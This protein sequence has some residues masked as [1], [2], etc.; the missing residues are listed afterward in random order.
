MLPFWAEI[1]LSLVA[2]GATASAVSLRARERRAL[3][4]LALRERRGHFLGE[5]PDLRQILKH[6]FSAAAEVLPVTRFDLYRVGSDF[7]VEEVWSVSSPGPGS[8]PEPVLEANSSHLGERIDPARLR[9]I[10]ATE[11]DRSFAPRDLL[12]GGPPSRRLRLPLYSGDRLIAHLDMTSSETVADATREEIRSLLGPLTASLH[13]FRNWT[14]AVTDELSGLASRRY[15][16]TRLSEEW[17]RRARYGGDLAVAS[18]DLDRFKAL[19]DSLGHAAGD[20]AIR[21]FGE[22]VRDAVRSSDIACRYG[23]EEF[24]VLFPETSG[25]AARAVAERIRSAVQAEIFESAGT[26][27]RITVSGGVADG[28]GASDREGLLVQADK[29]LYAAKAAGRDRIH[30]Y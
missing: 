16:E 28:G 29:A 11:T 1:F 10:T 17:A 20:V 25:E 26:P 30:A 15:F 22:I 5:S 12:S 13:A 6:A 2:A 9:E 27:F 4:R 18:F 14:I 21:R 8:D 23:G 19:N 3:A 24:A 7:R